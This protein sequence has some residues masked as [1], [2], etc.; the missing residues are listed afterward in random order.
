M[1][2]LVMLSTTPQ[3]MGSAMCLGQWFETEGEDTAFR[4][5]NKG[6][7][8]YAAGAQD[9]EFNSV[10]NEAM[11]ADSRYLTDLVVRECGEVFK[12]IGS[13][14][15]VGGGTGTMA[16]AI[17]K[18]F[19]HVKCTVLDLPQVV[20]GITCDNVEFIAGDM[21]EFI[22]PADHILLKVLLFFYRCRNYY[23]S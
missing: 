1:K 7:S 20:Q 3:F 9:A 8:L 6:Q 5:A 2:V 13:L 17:T 14:V 10:F 21:M 12:G 19:P 22:P 18:A 11:A 23:A 16:R 15:D 4:M